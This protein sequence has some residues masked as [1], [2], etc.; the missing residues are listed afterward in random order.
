MTPINK[1]VSTALIL[2]TILVILAGIDFKKRLASSFTEETLP[3]NAVVFTGQFH[4]I[5]S[6]LELLRQERVEHL[7]ISGV[8]KKAG[9][10][11]RGFGRQFG[12]DVR[13]QRALAIGRLVLKEQANTTLQN[14]AETACWYA[15]R[16]LEGPLLLITSRPHMPRA[17]LALESSL[18]DI[19]VVRLSLSSGDAN[20]S[21]SY[22]LT[23]FFKFAITLTY[24]TTFSPMVKATP[25]VG[26]SQLRKSTT[27]LIPSLS[28]KRM[29]GGIS[30]SKKEPPK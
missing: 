27:H 8:N 25:C 26:D 14:A 3:G 16:R 10:T 28:K 19:H 6:G 23:E 29:L 20:N 2:V 5:K 22:F 7:L 15:A 11:K 1:V 12:L 17:S 24:V 30:L 21:I 13:L 4:R 18:P 9:M